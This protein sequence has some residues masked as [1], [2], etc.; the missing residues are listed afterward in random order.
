MARSRDV[1]VP[2]QA[3]TKQRASGNKITANGL[4]WHHR[5]L[6]C[7]SVCLALLITWP[8]K[9]S[10]QHLE[11]FL[12]V[13]GTR[14]ASLKHW[15]DGAQPL[16]G[17]LDFFCWENTASSTRPSAR[18]SKVYPETTAAKGFPQGL[19]RSAHHLWA[20]GWGGA[21]PHGSH[22]PNEGPAN[23]ITKCCGGQA[24]I[25]KPKNCPF[26]ANNKPF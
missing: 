16:G 18:V 20:V 8:E 7:N 6:R 3:S 12:R 11:N 10:D 13:E 24:P 2:A 14:N 5:R 23:E 25:V 4:F 26:R 17:G 19:P 22:Q 15:R 21:F 1:A 9:A